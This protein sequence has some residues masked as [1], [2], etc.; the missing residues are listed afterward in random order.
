MPDEP[1]LRPVPDI[2]E[3]L[4]SHGD[5]LREFEQ[6]LTALEIT[7]VKHVQQAIEM[8]EML[9]DRSPEWV[10]NPELR[11][12]F[13]NGYRIARTALVRLKLV[14]LR[15]LPTKGQPRI[16]VRAAPV[17]AFEPTA[18]DIGSAL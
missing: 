14:E 8:F 16:E 4:E 12:T 3:V 5:L 13:G 17:I 15:T 10:A 2:L 11:R 1:E 7:R 18:D 6:R 9:K